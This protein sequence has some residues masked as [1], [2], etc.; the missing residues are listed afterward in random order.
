MPAGGAPGGRSEKS[1][2]MHVEVGSPVLARIQFC[3]FLLG[4]NI[5]F[6]NISSDFLAHVL[7]LT[8]FGADA[9]LGMAF[10]FSSMLT[11]STIGI[12]TL[13]LI[14]AFDR[15]IYPLYGDLSEENKTIIIWHISYHFVFGTLIGVFSACV[16]I[17]L[18]LGIDR[19]IMFTAGITVGFMMLSLIYKTIIIGD[20]ER[21]LSLGRDGHIIYS[22]GMVVGVINIML[23][24]IFKTIVIWD[25]IIWDIECHFCLGL[26]LGV[27]SGWLLMEISL[28]RDQHN[29]YTAGIL[30]VLMMLS[31]NFQFWS[32]NKHRQA[33]LFGSLV[34]T[35]VGTPT[36]FSTNKH[37]TIDPTETR[38]GEVALL[39]V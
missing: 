32:S 16:L 21:R 5:A 39:I 22:V 10:L 38:C 35:D 34:E 6:F 30:V 29:K 13:V 3:C 36:S 18:L 24:L 1:T 37:R 14:Y 4:L 19:H 17:D 33:T 2:K 23:T 20:I 9:G 11:C 31:L 7:T 27:S 26:L 8:V 25:I 12:D 28:G 15:L